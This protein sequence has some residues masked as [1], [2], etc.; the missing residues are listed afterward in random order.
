MFADSPP[1]HITSIVLNHYVTIVVVTLISSYC[2]DELLHC[3][4]IKE[5]LLISGDKGV[6]YPNVLHL[7]YW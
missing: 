4:V 7:F 6:N 5:E 3:V 1:P 2:V